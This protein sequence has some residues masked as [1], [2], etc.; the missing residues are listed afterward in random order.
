MCLNRKVSPADQRYL[1]TTL[2]S[3]EALNCDKSLG[4]A[5]NQSCR[6]Q[7]ND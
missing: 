6:L 2:T 4:G 7:Q 3:F 5:P 1:K